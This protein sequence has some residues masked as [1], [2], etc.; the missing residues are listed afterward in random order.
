MANYKGLRNARQHQILALL[1]QAVAEKRKVDR[2]KLIGHL[3]FQWGATRRTILE[4]LDALIHA[5]II[6]DVEWFDKDKEKK[7]K[8]ERE[9]AEQEFNECMEEMIPTLDIKSEEGKSE[10]NPKTDLNEMGVE[11]EEEPIEE[12]VAVL[13]PEL[14][15]KEE[16]EEI[17]IK[18]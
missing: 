17:Q 3:M 5:G 8:A 12:E 9:K 4:Y 15:D 10:W 16:T 18:S 1:R 14:K 6:D 13:K 2:E 7:E 11:E